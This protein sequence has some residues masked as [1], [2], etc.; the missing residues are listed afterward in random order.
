MAPR[1][2]FFRKIPEDLQTSSGTS[3][4][5][6][7]TTVVVMFYLI[8]AEYAAYLAS[9]SRTVSRVVMDS[10]QEDLL[11][12]NFNISLTS[13]PCHHVSVDVSDHMGQRFANITRHIRRFELTDEGGSTVRGE[14]VLMADPS[15]VQRWGAVT[16]E[17]H[18]GETVTP[19]LNDATFD[20]FMA[21]YEL[22]LVNYYAPWCPFSQ[23]LLPIWEQTALQLQ[24]HPEYSERVTMARV[25]CTQDNAVSLCRRA[26]IHAFPSMM[27]YMYGHTFTRYIYNGPRNAESLLLFLDLFYRRLNP[28][29]DF[30]EEVIPEFG[31]L[32][33]LAAPQNEEHDHDHEG[34]ELSGSIAVQRVP[35]KLVLYPYSGDQSFDMRDINVTHTINHFS[36]GQWKSTEQRMNNPRAV[37]STHYPMDAKHYRA[38]DS[39]ITIEHYIKIVGVDH[40][41]TI[42]FLHQIPERMYEFS[43][44]SNQYNA[45]NQVPAALFTYDSSPLVIELYTQSMPFFRFLTSLCAIVGGVYTVLGLV[46]AGVFHAVTSVQRKAKLGKLI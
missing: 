31:D 44:S 46:D 4:F 32:L 36:F 40:M 19:S 1:F 7:I 22:V 16:H 10:H 5:F 8:V 2:D 39:N 25:D 30:A 21:K 42:S 29:G 35:G 28:D 14:E 27:I 13:I 38:L 17:L 45:T 41:D 23:A 26:R 3:T 9:S 18:D 43:A 37:L 24:D 11:R 15:S 33:R 20:E 34:C 6:T 12:I